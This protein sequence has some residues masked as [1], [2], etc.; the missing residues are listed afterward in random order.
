[1]VGKLAGGLVAPSGMLL[2]IFSLARSAL[3]YSMLLAHVPR[4]GVFQ[5]RR[6]FGLAGVRKA[7]KEQRDFARYRMPQSILN[8]AALRLP[9]IMLASFFGLE[10][11]CQYPL[12][13][14]VLGATVMLLGQSVGEVFYTRITRAISAKDR[15]AGTLLIKATAALALLA[16]P[17]FGIMIV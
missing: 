14:L 8:A 6:W 9:V 10:V 11:A 4:T 13:V 17:T 16:V 7:A 3:N 5:V 12:S 15:S 1:N 2:I